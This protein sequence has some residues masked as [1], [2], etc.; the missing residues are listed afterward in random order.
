MELAAAAAAA[1]TLSV[2]NTSAAAAASG[3]TSDATRAAISSASSPSTG[4]LLVDLVLS[5]ELPWLEVP[6]LADTTAEADPVRSRLWTRLV[7]SLEALMLQN[8]TFSFNG[9]SLR[10]EVQRGDLPF[11]PEAGELDSKITLAWDTVPDQLFLGMLI[12]GFALG[13]IFSDSP[14]VG[15][16]QGSLGTQLIHYGPLGESAGPLEIKSADVFLE[17]QNSTETMT[18]LNCGIFRPGFGN[19]LY[20]VEQICQMNRYELWNVPQQLGEGLHQLGEGP[21]QL[22]EG[23]RQLGDSLQQLG[24]GPHQRQQRAGLQLGAVRQLE[25]EGQLE[26][27]QQLEAVGQLGAGRQLGAQKPKGN[28][29]LHCSCQGDQLFLDTDLGFGGIFSWDFLETTTTTTTTTATTTTSTTTTTTES[30]AENSTTIAPTAGTETTTLATT[31]SESTSTTVLGSTSATEQCSF[32]ENRTA[33]LFG[34]VVLG[35]AMAA[36]V[37]AILL[38]FL[39]LWPRYAT[40]GKEEIG[41]WMVTEKGVKNEK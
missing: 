19:E 25:A 17:L 15:N 41:Q 23:P 32:G 2:L 1:I 13:A 31:G 39:Y 40:V 35:L 7:E 4:P 34:A 11:P 26:G 16:A 28:Q 33:F 36:H 22:G 10:L 6:Y 14:V 12:R 21:R 30:I 37:A 9:T 8:S 38:H 24:E 29:L 20:W 3:P 18:N 5:D 27:G